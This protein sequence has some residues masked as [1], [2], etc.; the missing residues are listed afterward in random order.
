[1]RGAPRIVGVL[2][3]QRVVGGRAG[4]VELG[5]QFLAPLPDQRGR[6]QHKH[7]LDHAAQQIFL[8]HHARFHRLAEAHLV[9]EQ[10]PAVELF[11]HLAHGL[12][13]VP[14]RLKSP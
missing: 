11:E 9:G 13:L 6:G 8:Q 3:Q 1:M 5:L 2:A 14:E 12:G 10:D 4:D 7:A